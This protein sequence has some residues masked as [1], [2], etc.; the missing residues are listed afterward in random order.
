[1]TN[2]NV[3]ATEI[4][5]GVYFYNGFSEPEKLAN[6]ISELVEGLKSHEI[7]IDDNYT[8]NANQYIIDDLRGAVRESFINEVLNAYDIYFNINKQ[9]LRS[10]NVNRYGLDANDYLK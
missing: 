3:N 9:V 1:M 7:S 5:K 2:T 6:N 4:L 8:G 10:V